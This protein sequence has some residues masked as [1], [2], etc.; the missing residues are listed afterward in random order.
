MINR[1]CRRFSSSLLLLVC[2]QIGSVGAQIPS[3]E[4]LEQLQQAQQSSQNQ[5]VDVSQYIQSAGNSTGRS[6]SSGAAGRRSGLSGGADGMPLPY[7]AN[8]FTSGYEAER[9]DGLNASYLVAP[10]DK[11]SIQM[12]GTVNQAEV[13]TVD[14]QGN[15]FIPDIGPIKVKDVPA[16]RINSVVT[17]SI[18]TIY[19]NN[20]SVYVNLLTS[21]PVSV[22]VAGPVIRPGQ[23]AGLAS[24][25]VLFFLKRAGGVDPQRGSYRRISVMRNGELQLSYDLY[26]FL[27]EGKLP[28]F[29]FKD[30]DVILVEEQGAMVTVE[31]A[32]RY[33]FRFEL[34][35]QN[36][37]GQDLMFYARP[38]TKTSHVAV[39]G[40][41]QEGPI[42]VYFP[43]EQFDYFSIVDGDTVLFNDDLRPQVISV[44]ISGSYKGPSF[45]TVEKDA[46]LLDLL[47][48]VEV[49]PAQANF[50]AIYI[51]RESV[52]EQQKALIEDS[53]QRLERSIFTAPASSTGE[54]SI[55]AQE[56][57]LVTQFVARARQIQPLGKVIV[58]EN[59]NV[60][61]IRLE[62][63][64]EI[65]IPQ[66]TD[67]IQ[68]AGEVLMPQAIVYNPNAT[69][70]DYVAWAGGF[71]ERANDERIA[72]VHANGLTSF[73]DSQNAWLTDE[74]SQTLQA[75]DQILVLPKIDTKLLQAVKDITQIV[76]QIAIAANVVK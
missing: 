32:A 18:K 27:K 40:N 8:L 46:R 68:I 12:W 14:N 3:P 9:S 55:R 62:Q 16:S 20:V 45:Y 51:K 15:I 39:T 19:T 70:R 22:Y 7:G 69:I 33:P 6:P 63:G 37:S 74:G 24:D 48:Y 49:D 67:L 5:R 2:L 31:G 57:Q 43:L 25:S 47:S 1:Y 72:I 17:Q 76:Y 38:L 34:E 71:S 50:G 11:I 53:L 73:L 52:V 44:Q 61:N 42:S 29:S 35:A 59:G 13:V 28:A 10:G 54:A 75:G 21:T 23:Y 56:A 58:S 41:R 4:Q 30:N 26:D 36:S 64:D 66:Q 65:V 60:A